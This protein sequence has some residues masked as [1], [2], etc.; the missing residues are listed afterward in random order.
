ME[1]CL[2][3]NASVLG[4]KDDFQFLVNLIFLQA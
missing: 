2:T 3:K 4:D 1:T